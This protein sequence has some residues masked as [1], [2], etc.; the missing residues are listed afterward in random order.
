MTIRDL[1]LVAPVDEIL[2][3]ILALP[4]LPIPE[5][6]WASICEDINTLED[7]N[8][9]SLM[10]HFLEPQFQ[11]LNPEILAKLVNY[12]DHW[13][14]IRKILNQFIEKIAREWQN[15]YQSPM[16]PDE[17]VLFIKKLIRLDQNLLQ[18]TIPKLKQASYVGHSKTIIEFTQLYNAVI[19]KT[20]KP[21]PS[22]APHQRQEEN[23]SQLITMIRLRVMLKNLQHFCEKFRRDLFHKIRDIVKTH[24]RL[25]YQHYYKH[26]KEDIPPQQAFEKILEDREFI[27]DN[28]NCYRELRVFLKKEKFSKEV[29]N[30]I[31]DTDNSIINKNFALALN[32]QAHQSELDMGDT[33]GVALFFNNL[34]NLND[35][36]SDNETLF[37]NVLSKI[38][39]QLQTTIRPALE[40]ELKHLKSAASTD[41]S[42]P[43]ILQAHI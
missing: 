26:N 21:L 20:E 14:L 31:H 12:F 28:L 16:P 41:T 40:F 22:M 35:H 15:Y 27:S 29:L 4:Y 32:Y 2:K 11:A 18:Q 38:E 10:R 7:I 5:D 6:V 9:R 42:T 39:G 3:K 13:F 24:D 43:N 23:V 25:S 30:I 34:F 37:Y 1:I 36:I 17:M 33:S 19:L 8:E